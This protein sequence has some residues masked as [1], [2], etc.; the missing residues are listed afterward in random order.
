MI[1]RCWTGV[2]L[3]RQGRPG[4]VADLLAAALDGVPEGNFRL[5]HTSFLG[6]QA[7]ALG[8]IGRSRQALEAI[9]RSIAICERLNERWFF[10]E[11]LRFKGE[12]V[13]AAGDRGA[14]AL[15][16]ESFSS[17]L[18]WAKRQGALSWELRAAISLARL[19]QAQGRNDE[20]RDCL[21]PV[22]GQFGEGFTT[23]DLRTAA[24]LLDALA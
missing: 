14:A 10:P 11:L 3:A 2:L 5:H 21:A 9:D 13:L 18:D 15:A 23:A 16:E 6:E 1:S 8:R 7:H 19:R 22:Y 4:E 20:G 12:I 24:A 17:A